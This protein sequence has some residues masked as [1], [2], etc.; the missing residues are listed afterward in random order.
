MAKFTLRTP[1]PSKPKEP[2][3]DSTAL[4]DFAA[5]ARG[6]RSNRQPAPWE[7]YDLNAKPR[8]NVSIRMNDYELAV[9]RYLSEVLELSQHRIMHKYL[10]PLLK[11]M[12]IAE[13]GARRHK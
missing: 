1:V 4:E 7:Q 6:R 12:A 9:L 3:V 10:V 5:G 8:Y 2:E 11:Q 13:F